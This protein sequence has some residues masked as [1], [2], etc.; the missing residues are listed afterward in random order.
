VVAVDDHAGQDR[1]VFV[2]RQDDGAVA[3]DLPALA[4]QRQDAVGGSET[5]PAVRV[6]AL[7]L[8]LFV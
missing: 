7:P 1:V 2:R 5:A 6:H 8:P 3:V 4:Q